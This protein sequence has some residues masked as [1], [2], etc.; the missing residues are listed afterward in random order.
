MLLKLAVFAALAAAAALYAAWYV[1][2]FPGR[3]AGAGDRAPDPARVARLQ[4][5]VAALAGAIGP[6][7]LERGDSLER[8]ADWIEAACRGLP[9]P[10]ISYFQEVRGRKC[11]II[12]ATLAGD[13]RLPG[14]AVL[15][16]HY[17]TVAST[18]GAN[19]NASGVAALI[20]LA[21]E[22]A[23]RGA[24]ARSVRFVAFPNEEPPYF[25]TGEMG[26]LH[27]A[28]LCRS[29]GDDV[30]AMIALECLGCFRQEAGSQRYPPLVGSLYPDR[31]NFVAFV[32]DL[33]SRS[34][35]SRALGSFRAAAALPS[36]GACLPGGLPGVSWSDHWSFR[37]VDYPAIMVTDTAFFRDTCY[38]EP[39]DLPER[40]D[41]E[42]LARVVEGLVA[43]V[44]DLANE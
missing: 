40:A 13:G 20:E 18:P 39:G 25:Q 1:C 19:D 17:D 14:V 7:S 37:Q 8:A 6:R 9:L 29:R 34:L 23:A 27:Y 15:G 31:G 16:A 5:S 30:I 3:A 36:E 44:S 42:A 10:F 28:H 4:S 11:R 33:G 32:G 43:V 22:F 38:H 21:R 41:C 12:E 26:S 35:L 2:C 24:Q